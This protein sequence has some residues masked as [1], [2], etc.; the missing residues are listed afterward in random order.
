MSGAASDGPVGSA[1]ALAAAPGSTSPSAA[2]PLAGGAQPDLSASF[3]LAVTHRGGR[4]FRLVLHQQVGADRD[5]RD[6]QDHRGRAQDLPGLAHVEQQHQRR[7]ED[8]VAEEK[9]VV[10]GVFGHGWIGCRVSV[11]GCVSLRLPRTALSAALRRLAHPTGYTE[12]CRVRGR[13][14]RSSRVGRGRTRTGHR[15]AICR[16]LGACRTWFC[17]VTI[18][19]LNDLR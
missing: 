5:Q 18:N 14:G 12:R 3:P 6:P 19:S 11:D 16:I 7:A 2:A 8:Q 17:F 13:S 15:R 9:M 10:G 4:L 1:R